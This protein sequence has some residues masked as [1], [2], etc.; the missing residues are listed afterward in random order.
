MPIP[1]PRRCILKKYSSNDDGGMSVSY[2]LSVYG[3]S[4]DFDS[5]LIF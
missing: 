2:Y 4:Q 1:P 3:S 5:Y